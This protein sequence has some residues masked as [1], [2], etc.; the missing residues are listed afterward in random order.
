MSFTSV[1][2]FQA[3][4]QQAGH[5]P[6]LSIAPE[7]VYWNAGEWG[8]C[9]HR[10]FWI[11]SVYYLKQEQRNPSLFTLKVKPLLLIDYLKHTSHLIG[12]YWYVT[13]YGVE[14]PRGMC[15]GNVRDVW[16]NQKPSCSVK[17]LHC[18]LDTTAMKE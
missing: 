10:P 5:H 7:K 16:K 13:N 1:T 8:W 17:K 15:Q 3:H 14:S 6:I 12:T 18:A 11:Y 2:H 9:H 4:S